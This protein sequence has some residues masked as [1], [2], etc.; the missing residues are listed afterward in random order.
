M[1]SIPE[2][3]RAAFDFSGHTVLVV[4]ASS[5]GIGRAIADAFGDCGASVTIAGSRPVPEGE[6]HHKYRK[7]DVADAA[8]VSA[9]ADDIDELDV[10]VNA[11]AIA[12]RGEEDEGAMF[13][14]VLCTNLVAHHRLSGALRSALARRCG[15]IIG[16]SS[17]YARLATPQAP[18]YGA[19]KAALEQLTRSLAVALAPDRIRVNALAPGFVVTAQTERARADIKHIERVSARIP[20]GRWAVPFDMAGPAL[21]LASPAARY[22]TGTVLVADGGYSAT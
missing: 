11:A 14:R 5:T 10:F 21:F 6:T 16:I 9:L 12:R 13:Q 19:S 8:S 4:G 17:V 18:A 22:V 7:V 3:L 1:V 2:N 20:M 15:T